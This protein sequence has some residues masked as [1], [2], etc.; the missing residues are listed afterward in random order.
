MATPKNELDQAE[1]AVPQTNNMS[2]KCSIGCV[3]GLAMFS[4]VI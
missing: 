1:I 2:P 3:Q 4:D